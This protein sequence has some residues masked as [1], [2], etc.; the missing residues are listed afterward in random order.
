[1]IIEENVDSWLEEV[2]DISKQVTKVDYD[3]TRWP[4]ATNFYPP[5]ICEQWFLISIKV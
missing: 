3:N 4:T 5:L 1:M 2:C